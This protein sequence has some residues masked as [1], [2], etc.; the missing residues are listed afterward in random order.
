MDFVKEMLDIFPNA[1]DPMDVGERQIVSNIA[2]AQSEI[3][4]VDRRLTIH[5]T[6]S[7]LKILKSEKLD[8]PLSVNGL[9]ERKAQ[10]V[11]RSYLSDLKD[12]FK[13]WQIV[14]EFLINVGIDGLSVFKSSLTEVWPILGRVQNIPNYGVF[15]IGIYV[16][17]KTP[18]EINTYLHVFCT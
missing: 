4:F 8:V 17:S 12:S 3:W 14:E 18:N 13:M 10:Y 11:Y 6:H 2:L 5:C 1:S 7:L 16:V 9:L 15:M